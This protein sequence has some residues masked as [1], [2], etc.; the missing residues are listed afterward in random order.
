M[1]NMICFSV[2]GNSMFPTY[3]DGDSVWLKKFNVNHKVEV[4]DIIVFMHPLKE[5]CKIIKRVTRIK[6][7]S[8]LFVEGDNTDI[9]SSEDSHNFGYI[10]IDKLIAI[11]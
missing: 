3:R 4:D 7:G 8:Q 2:K 10:S 6:D 1:S 5:D 9:A 11:K